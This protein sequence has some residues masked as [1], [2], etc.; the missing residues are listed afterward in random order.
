MKAYF[1]LAAALAVSAC[2]SG[3][4]MSS[5]PEAAAP[6][7]AGKGRIVVYRTQVM[8]AAIQPAIEVNGRPTG[9][10]TPKGAFSVDVNP[11]GSTVAMTTERREEISVAVKEGQTSYVRCGVTFGV[12]IGAPDLEWVQETVGQSESAPLAFTGRH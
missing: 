8:G 7:P 9:K 6:I 2:A 5:A 12:L 11:G 3:T 4:P 10:C 1:A